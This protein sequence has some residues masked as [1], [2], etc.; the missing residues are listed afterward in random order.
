MSDLTVPVM[1]AGG[2]VSV[3]SDATRQYPVAQVVEVNA[4]AYTPPPSTTA[5]SQGLSMMGVG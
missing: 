3:T 1:G 4:E 5:T 2:P